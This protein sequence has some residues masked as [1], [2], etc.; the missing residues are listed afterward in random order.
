[1]FFRDTIIKSDL[2]IL[3]SILFWNKSIKTLEKGT[4]SFTFLQFTQTG[5]TK[6]YMDGKILDRI[7]TI[8]V[9]RPYYIFT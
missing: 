8:K 1:M 6:I 9:A 4:K 3:K 2:L 5:F 7:I